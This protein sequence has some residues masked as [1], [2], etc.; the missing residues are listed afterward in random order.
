MNRQLIILLGMVLM[1]GMSGCGKRKT[2]ILKDQYFVRCAVYDVM[3]EDIVV[4]DSNA[5]RVITMDLWPKAVFLLADGQHRVSDLISHL[6]SQYENGA[7][8][9]LDEQIYEV[10][11]SLEKEGIIR[12]SGKPEKLPYYLSMPSSELDMEKAKQ[13]MVQDGFIKSNEETV[14]SPGPD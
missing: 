6:A 14:Q 3:G 10:L 13:L 9:G 2:R 5:P 7:P 8:K 1:L 12:I 4:G 11:K